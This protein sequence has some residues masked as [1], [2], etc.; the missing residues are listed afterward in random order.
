MFRSLLYHRT[1]PVVMHIVADKKAMLDVQS[2]WLTL[3]AEGLQGAEAH[4]IDA[5]KWIDKVD[6]LPANFKTHMTACSTLRLWAHEILP[7]VDA[8]IVVDSGD[9]R[10]PR[11]PL[12]LLPKPC[13]EGHAAMSPRPA[14]IFVHVPR[15]AQ[16]PHTRLLRRHQLP[17]NRLEKTLRVANARWFL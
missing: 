10:S 8:T 14:R 11:W 1:V 17:A 16:A 9:V 7:D 2:I 5:E 13:V 6:A 4:F 3:E 12:C 15:G